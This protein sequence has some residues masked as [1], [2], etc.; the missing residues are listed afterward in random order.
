VIF[1]VAV[2]RFDRRQPTQIGCTRSRAKHRL[3]LFLSH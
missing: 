2:I 1:D 3:A